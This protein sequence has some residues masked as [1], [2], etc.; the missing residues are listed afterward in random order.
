MSRL[1]GAD[2]PMLG[3]LLLLN[4]ALQ[5]PV[6]S[7]VLLEGLPLEG[8]GLTLPLLCAAATRAGLSTRLVERDLDDIPDTSLPAILLLGK[9]RP[10]VLLQRCE[11]GR[12]LVALPGWDGGVQEVSREELLAQ[13][14][15]H[16]IFALPALQPDVSTDTE[17]VQPC[18]SPGAVLRQ[19]WLRHCER[20]LASSLRSLCQCRRHPAEGVA[21]AGG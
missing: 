7:A 1:T 21:G 10:C 18:P 19:S 12:F 2:D 17:L 20:L 9:N 13:H 4:R 16:A 6:P 8:Q 5:R 3:C 14:R 15:G 11:H